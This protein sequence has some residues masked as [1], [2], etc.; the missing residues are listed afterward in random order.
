M[1]SRTILDVFSRWFLAPSGRP[2]RP[3]LQAARRTSDQKERR[4]VGKHATIPIANPM[5]TKL[6]VCRNSGLV[7]GT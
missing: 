3:Y 1:M 2:T 6:Y 4:M 7:N 5:Y